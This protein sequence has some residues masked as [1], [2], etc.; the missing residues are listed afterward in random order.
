MVNFSELLA[1][2]LWNGTDDSSRVSVAF[3]RFSV[4]M[5]AFFAKSSSQYSNSLSD[6]ALSLISFNRWF[7]CVFAF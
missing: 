1:M 6:D 7:L 2:E 4:R 3:L 5:T